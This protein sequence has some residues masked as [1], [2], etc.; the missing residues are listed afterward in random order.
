MHLIPTESHSYRT[1]SGVSIFVGGFTLTDLDSPLWIRVGGRLTRAS[2]Q[3]DQRSDKGDM[4]SQIVIVDQFAATMASIQEA[5]ASLG[6]R[7][8]GQQA[9]QVPVQEET[10]F[11]T[12]VPPPPPHSQLE[13]GRASC[14]ERV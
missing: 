13:I 5:I 8:D 3:L 12:T 1:L 6:Q 10:Q 14:R 9:Q 4:D 2:N 7:I 11:D